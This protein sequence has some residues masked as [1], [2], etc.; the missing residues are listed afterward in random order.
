MR[1]F[2]TGGSGYIGRATIAELVRRGH[3][4][5]ALARSEQSAQAVTGTG[6]SRQQTYRDVGD[7][8][9]QRAKTEQAT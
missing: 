4:V 8:W 6:R 9:C 1:I 7:H 2:L 5:E 3:S